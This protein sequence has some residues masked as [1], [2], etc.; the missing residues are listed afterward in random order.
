MFSRAVSGAE[1]P[2]R[3]VSKLRLGARGLLEPENLEQVPQSLQARP[4][5]STEHALAGR[6]YAPGKCD[7][8]SSAVGGLR[9]TARSMLKVPGHVVWGER[10]GSLS[11]AHLDAHPALQSHI[12]KLLAPGENKGDLTANDV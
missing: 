12:L 2:V 8:E 5:V 11:D 9:S 10:I 7:H 6:T 3:L 1:V 4:R